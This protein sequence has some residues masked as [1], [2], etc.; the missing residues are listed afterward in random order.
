V[1][2]RWPVLVADVVLVVT[3]LWSKWL[4]YAARTGSLSASGAW[5]GSSVLGV[6][7]VRPGDP[8]SWPAETSFTS[9]YLEAVMRGADA[10]CSNGR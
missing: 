8:P 3:L 4:P 1:R 6:G 2:R 5:D 9:A 7:A 10:R